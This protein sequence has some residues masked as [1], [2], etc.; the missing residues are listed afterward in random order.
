MKSVT[1]L[2]SCDAKIPLPSSVQTIIRSVTRGWGG[3]CSDGRSNAKNSNAYGVINIFKST[4]E[5]T[6]Q[7]MLAPD[8]LHHP[9]QTSQAR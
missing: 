5:A 4:D 8:L 3:W 1:I 7:D 6:D 2:F 9:P